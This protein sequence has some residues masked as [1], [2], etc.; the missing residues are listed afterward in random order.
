I[1]VRR[2]K[3]SCEHRFARGRLVDGKPGEFAELRPFAAQP[4]DLGPIEVVC[5]QAF[6]GIEA[7]A[8]RAYKHALVIRNERRKVGIRSHRRNRVAASL[9]PPLDERSGLPTAARK[10]GDANLEAV[11]KTAGS[12]ERRKVGLGEGEAAKTQRPLVDNRLAGARAGGWKQC[13]DGFVVARSHL[14]GRFARIAGA[15]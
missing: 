7:Y 15:V 11:V 9:I 2:M 6:F 3:E 10:L 5:R 4:V 8:D 13:I 1:Q 14:R 12:V